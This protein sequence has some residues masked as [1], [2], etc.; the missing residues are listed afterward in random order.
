MMFDKYSINVGDL[1]QMK[2]GH[3][4][5][6]PTGVDTLDFLLI[7]SIEEVTMDVL[8]KDNVVR[9]FNVF[10]NDRFKVISRLRDAEEQK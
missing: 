4:D 5:V 8:T 10:A 6:Y 1:V 2:V 9:R 3:G 7:L